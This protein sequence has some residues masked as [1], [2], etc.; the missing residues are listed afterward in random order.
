MTTGN[1]LATKEELAQ[2][3]MSQAL[4]RVN[5][6]PPMTQEAITL[7]KVFALS[8]LFPDIASSAQAIVKILA[9]QELGFPAL[10]SMRN[11]FIIPGTAKRAP[12]VYVSTEAYGAKLR[13]AG[14]DFEP[15][16]QTAERCV[17]RL[18]RNGVSHE[19]TYTMG[20]ARKAGLVKESGAWVER[21]EWM[22]YT[23]ALRN[24]AKQ[25]ASDIIA[26]IEG[27]VEEV[28]EEID[29]QANVNRPKCA[30]H[31]VSMLQTHTGHWYC[32]TL[33][34]GK[35]CQYQV[36]KS[37][38]ATTE[39]LPDVAESVDGDFENVEVLPEPA[40]PEQIQQD[41]SDL[42]GPGPATEAQAH[43]AQQPAAATEGNGSEAPSESL[44]HPGLPQAPPRVV[45]P[46]RDP[47]RVKSYADLLRA[48][49][50]DFGMQPKTVY[51]ELGVTMQAEL[52][53]SASDCYRRI[54]AVYA[55]EQITRRAE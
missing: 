43:I 6:L 22:L 44:G 12:Q 35:Y 36:P 29:A 20:Q 33:V 18:T 55:V 4:A 41:I 26:G 7:G 37:E 38:A 49:H 5:A 28:Q 19:V 54:A 3:A 51:G 52:M 31:G 1:K 10:Y 50:V 23:K 8:G 9:G 27:V 11:V 25:F 48:C 45:K 39:V 14:M 21:P 17:I 24:A 47:D 53:E 46:P 30:I 16:E 34:N 15:I 2:R 40:P 13:A 42:F 32:R